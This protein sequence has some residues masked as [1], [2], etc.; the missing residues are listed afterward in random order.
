MLQLYGIPHN[1]M[2]ALYGP[3]N[4]K[5]AFWTPN[6]TCQVRRICA[7]MGTGASAGPITLALALAP[8]QV[9]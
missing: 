1:Q 5:V 6:A 9:L 7:S 3:F 4:S 2:A 8:L